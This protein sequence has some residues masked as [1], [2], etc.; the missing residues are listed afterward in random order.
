M[1]LEVVQALD[2][3]LQLLQPLIQRLAVG[4]VRLTQGLVQRVACRLALARYS[5]FPSFR[6]LSRSRERKGRTV[7]VRTNRAE[8]AAGATS[9]TSPSARSRSI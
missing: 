1:L 5:P 6:I 9:T 8:I 3:L 4:I 2:C 7:R